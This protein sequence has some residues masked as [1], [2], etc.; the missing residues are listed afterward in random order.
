MNIF[1]LISWIFITAVPTY[2]AIVS[3]LKIKDIEIYRK[4]NPSSLPAVLHNWL[5]LPWQSNNSEQFTSEHMVIT[6]TQQS[7]YNSKS[8]SLHPTYVI[9]FSPGK[10]R[11]PG[12][13][14]FVLFLAFFDFIAIINPVNSLIDNGL[15][16]SGVY[17]IIVPILIGLVL[18]TLWVLL[19]GQVIR[20]TTMYIEKNAIYILDDW[21]DRRLKLSGNLQF[22]VEREK[23]KLFGEFTYIWFENVA[24]A[25]TRLLFCPTFLIK[26]SMKESPETIVSAM[27]KA[28]SSAAYM[29]LP[30]QMSPDAT[31]N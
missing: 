25:K 14:N 8:F 26:Y 17:S 19:S 28:L 7:T 1:E 15:S 12:N 24:E 6:P 29:G 22:S 20:R 2:G 9:Y 18:A 31:A 16:I 5:L 3:F 11:L 4:D 23:S 30:N 21:G 10:I 13:S 27:N